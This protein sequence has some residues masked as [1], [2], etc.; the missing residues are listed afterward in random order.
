MEKVDDLLK[1]FEERSKNAVSS[2]RPLWDG[3]DLDED[4]DVDIHIWR[5]P[6]MGNSMQT[7]VG[8]TI[9][10]VTATFSFLNTLLSKEVITPNTLQQMVSE[11][12]K[13]NKNKNTKVVY[14]TK[15]E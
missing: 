14:K 12:I 2:T 15:E 8:N 5:H 3:T 13:M 9:S 11:V 7:V 6:G 4:Y 10:I 1:E